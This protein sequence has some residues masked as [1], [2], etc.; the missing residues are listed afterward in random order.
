M[1]MQN[2]AYRR[3]LQTP[4]NTQIKKSG[5]YK[6]DGMK[7]TNWSTKQQLGQFPWTLKQFS[8]SNTLYVHN[9]PSFYHQYLRTSLS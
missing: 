4:R 1:R 2:F 7:M 3:Y 6:Y 5:M 9:I 8:E